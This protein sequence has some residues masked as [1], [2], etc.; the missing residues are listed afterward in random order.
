MVALDHF[1]EH[2]ARTRDLRTSPCL[3]GLN[4]RDRSACRHLPGA[5]P[6]SLRSPGADDEDS[7]VGLAASASVV[8]EAEG[9]FAI[10]SCSHG[11]RSPVALVECS[12]GEGIAA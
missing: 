5:I 2:P 12:L 10:A 8:S 3:Y 9:P 1:P 11:R 6:S 4:D 7:F